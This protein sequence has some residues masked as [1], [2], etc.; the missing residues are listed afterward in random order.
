MKRGDG[1]GGWEKQR[2]GQS[3]RVWRPR[4]EAYCRRGINK[5]QGGAWGN[6]GID[7]QAAS[8]PLLP[9]TYIRSFPHFVLQKASPSVKMTHDPPEAMHDIDKGAKN[10]LEMYCICR[11]G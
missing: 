3:R 5:P 2:I 7:R 6:G 4:R 9:R 1:L 10:L 11:Y 8:T